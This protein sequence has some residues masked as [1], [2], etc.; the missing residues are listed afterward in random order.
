MN[1]G[2]VEKWYVLCMVRSCNLEN[3]WL[4]VV[5]SYAL[6]TQEELIPPFDSSLESISTI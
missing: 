6:I 1:G 3:K 5:Y 2:L 4:L